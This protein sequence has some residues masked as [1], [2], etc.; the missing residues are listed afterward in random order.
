MGNSYQSLTHKLHAWTIKLTENGEFEG[1][2]AART[3]FDFYC[4][5]V[6]ANSTEE[7]DRGDVL[8]GCIHPGTVAR[9]TGLEIRTVYKVNNW[10]HEQGFVHVSDD[11]AT[12][13][14]RITAIVVLTYD[15]Q[16]ERQR[17]LVAGTKSRTL[18]KTAP[19]VVKRDGN[20]YQIVRQAQ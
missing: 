5:H 6:A 4:Q 18:L 9:K 13:Y 11:V 17:K 2:Q 14:R 16:S 1:H 8:P 20:L 7:Y 10:L 12:K 3:V 19:K 15:E